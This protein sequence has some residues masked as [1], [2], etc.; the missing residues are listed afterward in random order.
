MLTVVSLC[1]AKAALMTKE[2][3]D[4]APYFIC[5]EGQQS[6][7]I[8]EALELRRRK[9]ALYCTTVII[10]ILLVTLS[11][12]PPLQD[13]HL[14]DAPSGAKALADLEHQEL[15]HDPNLA[16]AGGYIEGASGEFSLGSETDGEDGRAFL[17]WNHTAGTQLDFPALP[18]HDGIDCNDYV[19]V[20]QF[21]RWESRSTPYRVR[22]TMEYG[23]DVT[24]T[25]KTNESAW[26][27]FRPFA[28]LITPHY[29]TPISWWLPQINGTPQ[30]QLIDLQQYII[31]SAWYDMEYPLNEL[32]LAIGFAPTWQFNEFYDGSEPWRNYTGAVTMTIEGLSVEALSGKPASVDEI[33]P[34]HV[35]Y[36]SQSDNEQ[37]VDVEDAG[38]GTVY[39]LSIR[40]GPAPYRTTLVRWSENADVLW[41]SK[42]NNSCSI[43]CAAINV[44][45]GNVY[46][47]GLSYTSTGHAS[48]ILLRW[49]SDG[50]ITL[51]KELSLEMDRPCDIKIANDD[52]IYITGQRYY[53]DRPYWMSDYLVKIDHDGTLIWEVTLG[54]NSYEGASL[55]V[56]EEDDVYALGTYNLT[57]WDQDANLLWNRTGLFIDLDLSPSGS[58]C[59]LEATYYL[60]PIGYGDPHMFLV[61]RDSDGIVLN[62]QSID[63][64]Y[65]ETWS[66][67][68][69]PYSLDIAVDGSLYMLFEI[70]RGEQRV[71]LG[72]YNR[73]GA[74]LWNKSLSPLSNESSY[75]FYPRMA[76]GRNGLIHI[77]GRHYDTES[78]ALCFR[79]L[80]YF[81]SDYPVN[82]FNLPEA[83]LAMAFSVIA[84]LVVGD[85]VRRR[86]GLRLHT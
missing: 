19:Y 16:Y 20:S 4:F 41:S 81:D 29:W 10:F 79:M 2:I 15:A 84:V 86:K 77:I 35:G 64:H 40:S 78:E 57:K 30:S 39:S 14:T 11:G 49:S 58:A 26:G 66:E 51:A 69:W 9:T 45:S 70:P 75:W 71:R 72:K 48:P 23:F 83:R 34:V 53:W 21:L 7:R 8:M 60:G 85:I 38:D 54:T 37:I 42:T 22:V 59:T 25:F 36:K 17:V 43:Q 47:I 68:I 44:Y 82:L 65:T 76:L 73:S 6:H 80:V 50:T 67:P 74:Q 1:I 24:G 52:F 46:A 32:S 13:F 12:A 3:S 33:E 62:N 27:M 31:D 28:Y 18:E 61:E 5:S 55:E 56:S 63:I